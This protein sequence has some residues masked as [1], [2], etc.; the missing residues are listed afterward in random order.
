ML[1]PIKTFAQAPNELTLDKVQP[2]VTLGHDQNVLLTPPF[3]FDA[4]RVNTL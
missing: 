1:L 3:A 2:V 4:V